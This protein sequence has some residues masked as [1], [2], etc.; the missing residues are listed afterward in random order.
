MLARELCYGGWMRHLIAALLLIAM[1]AHGAEK[2]PGPYRMTVERVLDG[3]SIKG[4][5]SVW[6]GTV[7][8]ATIRIDGIDTPEL[9]GKCE[10]EKQKAREAR[11]YLR[12]M[13][14]GMPLV[15]DVRP[16][17][18]GGRYVARLVTAQGVDVAAGMI[19]A[20]LARPYDGGKRQPWC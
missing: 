6:P 19:A 15:Y 16:D 3:D 2:Y 9:R 1:P 13:L 12:A 18:Y 14:G 17:K 20:G 8:E 5:V 11:D 4:R 7:I 10:A